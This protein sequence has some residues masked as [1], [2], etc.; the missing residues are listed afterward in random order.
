MGYASVELSDYINLY[1]TPYRFIDTISDAGE[2][3]KGC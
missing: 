3:N 2:I 1:A